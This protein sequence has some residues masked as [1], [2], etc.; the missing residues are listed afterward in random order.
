MT[1]S[2]SVLVLNILLFFLIFPT[3]SFTVNRG[4]DFLG[5]LALFILVGIS[6]L[7]T[8]TAEYKISSINNKRTG[9]TNS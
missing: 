6:L 9:E 3:L 8:F 1:L 4:H 7:V 2:K 5:A